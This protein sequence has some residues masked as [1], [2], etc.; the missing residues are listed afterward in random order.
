MNTEYL[1]INIVSSIVRVFPRAAYILF[2]LYLI[3]GISSGAA[4]G[5]DEGIRTLDPLLA[6]QMLSQLS[7]TP[8]FSC[9]IVVCL[10]SWLSFVP[11]GAYILFSLYLVAGISSG[12]ITF[13]YIFV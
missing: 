7:Y 5:G 3:A 4:G 10:S 13:G 8:I 1:I 2:S 6:G 9:T 11:R 12:F